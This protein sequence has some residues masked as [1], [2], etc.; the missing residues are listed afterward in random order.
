MKIVIEAKDITV[1]YRHYESATRSIKLNLLMNHKSQKQERFAIQDF[2]IE[3]SSEE[4]V[5]SHSSL[6]GLINGD[7]IKTLASKNFFI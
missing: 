5:L 4:G 3:I 7:E 2:S 1:S 6:P